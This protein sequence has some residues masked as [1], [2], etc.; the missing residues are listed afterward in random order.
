MSHASLRSVGTV[1]VSSGDGGSGRAQDAWPGPGTSLQV[2][3]TNQWMQ[4]LMHVDTIAVFDYHSK[5]KEK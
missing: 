5:V 4:T 2:R 3:K 1:I